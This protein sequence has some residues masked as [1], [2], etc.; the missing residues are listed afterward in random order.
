METKSQKILKNIAASHASI[1]ALAQGAKIRRKLMPHTP[2]G[3][4]DGPFG[5]SPRIFTPSM[6]GS[7]W[8]KAENVTLSLLK[9]DVYDRRYHVLEEPFTLEKVIKGAFSEKNRDYDDMPHSGQVR[10][11]P[12]VLVEEGGRRNYQAWA[13][14]YAFPCQKPVGQIILR[15]P[16]MAGAP[17]P[18]AVQSMEDG[19]SRIT[20]QGEGGAALDLEYLM[21]VAQSAVAVKVAYQNQAQPPVFALYRHTDQAHRKYMDSQGNFIPEEQR[22][23]VYWPA[24]GKK[25]RERYRFEDDAAFNGPFAPPT[26]GADG[27]FFWIQQKFPADPTFPEGFTYVMMGL[28][29][30]A[31][32]SFAQNQKDLGSPLYAEHESDE[33]GN[34][35]Q[36][37]QDKEKRIYELE[38]ESGMGAGFEGEFRRQEYV[39]SMTRNAP[40]SAAYARL[41]PQSGACV[42]YFVVV[43]SN[44]ASDL[45]AEAKRRLLALK[46]RGYNALLQEN[47][48]WYSALYQRRQEGRFYLNAS[49]KAQSRIDQLLVQD[50][51]KSWSSPLAGFCAPD[52]AKLE[53]G[54]SF[55][56]FDMDAQSWHSMPCYNEL[57]C[58]PDLVRRQPEWLSLWVKLVDFWRDA[59]CEKAKNSFGL[60][61]MTITHGYLPP[62]KPDSRYVQN[63]CLD[64]CL[65]TSAQV[66]KTLWDLWDYQGDEA[67]LKKSVYPALREL[68]SFFEAFARRGWDGTY[69]HLSPV[70]E[71]ENWGISYKLTYAT[72]TTAALC[73][74]KKIFQCAIEAAS[75]L[76]CDADKIPGWQEVM[77]RLAPY[78]KFRIG[79][80]EILGGN[81]GAIPRW[82]AGD[83]GHFTG[84]YPATLADE[85]NLDSPQ[86]E[87]DLIIRSMDAVRCDRDDCAYILVGALP[88]RTPS[89]YAVD[90]KPIET[91]EQLARQLLQEPER[92]LNSRS[93]RIHLFPA[94]PVW[95]SAAFTGFLARGGFEV[96]A[97]RDITGVTAV[98]V[99]ARRSVPLRLMNPWPGQMVI[100]TDCTTGA[101]VP[102]SVCRQNGEC[103]QLQAQA[104]HC[105]SFDVS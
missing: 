1:P 37:Q 32:T 35:L 105:Y 44:D 49:E 93:G 19:V 64:F 10:A 4:F 86:E 75:L 53:G 70:V 5:R 51:Y 68:A 72:D 41:S 61:G 83:H 97:A 96:S 39:Y 45:I 21:S 92:L 9:N 43:T 80:G 30:E 7:L 82:S 36:S 22:P 23:V 60:P 15:A 78:P 25:E 2:G 16:G 47:R 55:A 56:G 88:D 54:A 99:K 76:G 8:G 24:D 57:F 42:A 84:L 12:G 34:L 67:L 26:S 31:A 100:V 87:K 58:T 18:E 71:P 11:K 17:Q 98:T 66:V 74:F 52:P 73:M 59:L 13:S 104:G 63:Q 40:G 90:A 102:A 6:K 3:M 28:A 81:P 91:P 20:L 29:G 94:V 65:D 79:G 95:A 85:I 48:A 89:G 14:V 103:L 69:Y 33:V 62:I 27:P 50:A 38:L 101:L 77:E 46:E